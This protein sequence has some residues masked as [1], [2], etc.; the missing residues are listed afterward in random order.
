MSD[1]SDQSEHSEHSEPWGVLKTAKVVIPLS[2]LVVLVLFAFQ[3]HDTALKVSKAKGGECLVLPTATV[4][5]VL[6]KRECDRPHTGEV[7]GTFKYPGEVP[8]GAPTPEENCQRLP[9]DLTPQQAALAQR[10]LDEI[11]APGNTFV[12]VT[13]NADST[14]DRHYACIVG[15]PERTGSYLAEVASAASPVSGGG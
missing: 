11:A 12:L 1:Q 14:K 4:S 5:K 13:N 2:I 8:P 7:Y 3:A 9:D 15:F 6:Q 10:M